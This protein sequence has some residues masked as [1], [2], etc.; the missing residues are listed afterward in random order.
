MKN[1]ISFIGFCVLVFSSGCN[2]NDDSVP[3]EV[4]LQNE[5]PLSF[6]LI[7]MADKAT[8]VDILPTLNWE[9]AKNAKGG[10]VTYDLYLGKETNPTTL[11]KT[12]IPGTSYEIMERLNLSTDYYWKVVATDT[13][14]RSS[15]SP[16]HKFTIRDIRIS[17][18]P[19]AIAPYGGRANHTSLSFEDKLWVFGGSYF[20]DGYD[21]VWQSTDGINWSEAGENALIR[22][23]YGHTSE[24]YDNKMWMLGGRAENEDLNIIYSHDV[25]SSTDGA[26]WANHTSY[27]DFFPARTGHS[28]VIHKGKIYIIGGYDGTNAQSDIWQYDGNW[29]EVEMNGLTFSPRLSHGSVVFDDKIWV[30][31]GFDYAQNIKNK[32]DVWFSEDGNNWTQAL[33]QAPFS[34][35]RGHSTV[36]YDDKL[37]VIGG[38]DDSGYSN[39]IWYTTDGVDWKTVDVTDSLPPRSGHSALVHDNKLWIIGGVQ[40][41]EDLEWYANDV[42]V[43]E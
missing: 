12:D 22:P 19:L 40:A 18:E 33:A 13:D 16:V 8:N 34:P 10:D 1:I 30:I 7:D 31:G 24:V 15:Q 43:F 21:D 37:W 39:E 23:K 29:S 5:P 36:V 28:S 20:G 17:D 26:A 4:E 6:N 41:G 9:S 27:T 25:W 38:I 2:K 42:W 14:G 35:R 11:F 32:N 3:P